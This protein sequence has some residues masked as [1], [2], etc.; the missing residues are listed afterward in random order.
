MLWE[1]GKAYSQDLR[2]LVSA[3]AD[4]G[5]TVGT[6]VRSQGWRSFRAPFMATQSRL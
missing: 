6:M 5:A 1:H 3:E 4:N 2:V